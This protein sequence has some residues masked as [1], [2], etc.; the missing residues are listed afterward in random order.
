MKKIVSILLVAVML[1]GSL[2]LLTGCGKEEG[3]GKS[4]SAGKETM[5]Y[6]YLGINLRVL[7]DYST[8]SAYTKSTNLDNDKVEG[9]IPDE[10]YMG[11]K[12][13]IQYNFGTYIMPNINY[14]EY[15]EYV[16]NEDEFK[17]NFKEL[18]IN[19]RPAFYREENGNVYIVVDIV[20]V[21]DYVYLE[22]VISA[23]DK[24]SNGVEA[25]K[26][27]SVQDV[28][29]SIRFERIESEIV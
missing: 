10:V 22:V 2:F 20:D 21:I 23:V 6:E 24:N 15:K 29:N 27:K 1:I 25:Y 4:E 11:E 13:K 9:T 17:N 28:I 16:K 26:D 18:E 14:T 5:V 8:K 3:E 7:M 12:A 19:G